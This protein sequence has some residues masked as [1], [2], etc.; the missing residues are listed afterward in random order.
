ME[1]ICLTSLFLRILIFLYQNVLSRNFKRLALKKL[2]LYIRQRLL[3]STGYFC[4]FFICH[5]PISQT[6]SGHKLY[7]ERNMFVYLPLFDFR[8]FSS[9]HPVADLSMVGSVFF[10]LLYKTIY[11]KFQINFK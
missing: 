7:V 3:H 1:R 9:D 2:D 11:L 6:K 10:T 5:L 8:S 4:F